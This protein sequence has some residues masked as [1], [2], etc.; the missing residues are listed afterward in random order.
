M[1]TYNSYIS[2]CTSQEF[3]ALT[4]FIKKGAHLHYAIYNL[5]FLVELIR[6]GHMINF[7]AVTSCGVS[8]NVVMLVMS[9]CS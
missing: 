3:N 8:W 5:L 7:E 1:N 4:G 2:Q 9:Y 6:K